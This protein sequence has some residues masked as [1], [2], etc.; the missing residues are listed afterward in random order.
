MG[1]KYT[2]LTLSLLLVLACNNAQQNESKVPEK[3]NKVLI[4]ASKGSKVGYIDTDGQ[5]VIQ[6]QFEGA[7][8]FNNHGLAK[9]EQNARW[10]LLTKAA[11]SSL[12]QTILMN[13]IFTW[14]KTVWFVLSFMQD[15]KFGF[16]DK[17]GKI[18]VEPI[19]EDATRFDI[20]DLAVV[21]INGKYGAIDKTGKLVIEP[22]YDNKI[23]IYSNDYI[24]LSSDDK[25]GMVSA[26]LDTII[27]FQYNR[28]ILFPGT[29][30]VFL[31][32]KNNDG[33]PEYGIFSKGKY[34]A[35][36]DVNDIIEY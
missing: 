32:L 3:T 21:K 22:K 15:E 19:Y 13:A 18:V 8:N 5:W 31:T 4:P 33:N 9:I 1:V 29:N 14:I 23:I 30:D 28:I 25:C 27:D 35:L 24:V 26:K 11:K 36:K 17:T 2:L 16:I 6:P 34:T 10:A 20:N 12:L 7:L